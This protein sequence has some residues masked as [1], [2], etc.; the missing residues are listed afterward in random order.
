MKKG[1][2]AKL[3][4]DETINTEGHVKIGRVYLS[5][6]FLGSPRHQQKLV[7]D[8]L[9]IVKRYGKPTY[10]IT[11]SCNPKWTEITSQ[12]LPGQTAADRPDITVR[13]F[14][15]KLADL[16]K[17]ILKA[18]KCKK[19]VYRIHVIEFQKRGLP[20]AHI[21]IKVDN[22]PKTSE[23]IDA[24]I[25][26]RMPDNNSKLRKIIESLYVHSCRPERCHKKQKQ[27]KTYRIPVCDQG[28]PHALCQK[29]FIDEAGF[30]HYKRTAEEDRSIVSYNPHL[31][32]G[33]ECHINVDI[34]HTVLLIMYL[35]KYFYKGVDHTR[36][37]LDVDDEISEYQDTRYLS[38]SEGAWRFLGFETTRRIP[39]VDGYPVHVDKG[40]YVVFNKGKG[41]EALSTLSKLERYFLRP[42]ELIFD[43]IKYLEY[44]E[45]YMVTATVPL[46]PARIS[47]KPSTCIRI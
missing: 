20:H 3:K 19:F 43:N 14:K 39:S 30:V 9:A 23:E 22:E 27:E 8:A 15:G 6:E 47:R 12:L 10:F 34:A 26:A 29:T 25:S 36:V 37:R 18:L 5:S 2:L 17:I 21:A 24:V 7:A 16:F 13:V 11:M 46:H 35:Y 44:Y 28:Y 40:N 32:F 42:K 33:L 1:D 45:Q 38:S 41:E 31:T 4:E